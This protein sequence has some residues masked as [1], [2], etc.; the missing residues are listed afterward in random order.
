MSSIDPTP[1]S[2][3][4]V[5]SPATACP[6]CA[7]ASIFPLF[8]RHDVP[9]LLNRLYDTV[10]AAKRAVTGRLRIVACRKCGFVF[11]AAFDPSLIEYDARYENDQGNSPAFSAHMSAM[12]D[13]ILDGLTDRTG[14]GVVEIGCGQ[15]RFLAA[16]VERAGG[17][18]S[19]A[20]GY[21]PAWRGGATPSPICVEAQNFDAQGLRRLP[22]P[23][24]VILSRH[25]IEHLVN[26][27][28]FLADIRNA[29]PSSW[30]GRLFLETPSLEWIVNGRVLHDFF[31]EH[32]NYFSS[33]AL[34]HALAR[35]GFRLLK[36][37]SVFDGQYHWVEAVA[38][39]VDT[40]LPKIAD[41]LMPLKELAI[42]ERGFAA[43]WQN[44][45]ASLKPKGHIAIW[46]AGAKG[47]TF[48]NI[49][50]PRSEWITCFIDINPQKQNRFVPVTA[51]PVRHPQEA[52]HDGIASIIIM[53]P[54]YRAEICAELRRAGEYP[55][56][57][58]A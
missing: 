23:I 52:M 18:I 41:A 33:A 13:R 55:I 57:L 54:I 16:L 32:C 49:V 45:L 15:A 5:S 29:L 20:I 2:S 8:E 58:D 12:A 11:N 53:N 47:V 27:V 9:V 24:D 14:I 44:T 34:A 43:V 7:G 46:G 19:T 56:L 30:N 39:R 25:V 1:G 51:H 31:H 17:R 42:Y 35:A 3:A 40:A 26:P 4:A 48:A 28:G 50:D 38:D 10:A 21:D 37:D 6:L 22:H 36:I